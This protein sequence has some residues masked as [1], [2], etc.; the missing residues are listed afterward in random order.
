MSRVIE[1]TDD[2]VIVRLSGWTA[3]AA[4]ERELRI[5]IAALTFVSTDPYQGNGLR[6]GG[7]S[8]PFTD[9]RAGR[10]RRHGCGRLSPSRIVTT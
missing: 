8:I 7:T 10:F 5:P 4:P 3:V 6:L 1:V 9:I 2:H